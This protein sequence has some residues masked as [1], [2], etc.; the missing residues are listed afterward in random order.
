MSITDADREEFLRDDFYNALRYLFE[1]AIAWDAWKQS[2][3]DAFWHQGALG[4]Y[5]TFMEARALYDFFHKRKTPNDGDNARADHFVLRWE[6]SKSDVYLRYMAQR[7]PVNKRMFHLIYARRAHSGETATAGPLKEQ[8]LN[9]ARDLCELS[10]EFA[11]HI[12]DSMLQDVARTAL[13]SALCEA[14]KAANH[15]GIANPLA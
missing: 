12:K 2:E 7:K 5:T 11:K 13:K 10:R 6:G 14:K 9:V 15:Y 8:V 3:N 4:M 1:G